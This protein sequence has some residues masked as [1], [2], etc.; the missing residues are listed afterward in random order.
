[1]SHMCNRK[2]RGGVQAAR[3][4]FGNVPSQVAKPAVGDLIRAVAKNEGHERARLAAELEAEAAA[5]AA[6]IQAE[7]EAR[8]FAS[9][10]GSLITLKENLHTR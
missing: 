9:G 6:R 4:V 2:R 1:M 5:E 7:R 10:L 3:N 8:W